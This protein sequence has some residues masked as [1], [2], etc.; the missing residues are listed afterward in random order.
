M[1]NTNATRWSGLVGEWFGFRKSHRRATRKL[2]K[3]VIETLEPRVLLST[4]MNTN[5]SGG[6][7]LRA[8]I[9]AA[10]TAGGAQTINFASTLTGQTINL[11]SGALMLNDPNGTLTIVGPTVGSVTV[12]AGGHSGVFDVA[13]GSNAAIS[14]LTITEGIDSG[15]LNSGSLTVSDCTISGNST[16]YRGGGVCNYYGTLTIANSTITRNSATGT[17][18]G[19]Y[20]FTWSPT[21]T[22]ITNSTIEYN[23]AS[24]GGGIGDFG[25]LTLTGCAIVNNTAT[26]TAGGII[27]YG[28]QLFT[29]TNSTISHNIGPGAG[30]IVNLGGSTMRI[31][32]STIAGNI[33]GGIMDHYRSQQVTLNGTIV[34]NNT[35]NGAHDLS[36][37][38]TGTY[39]LVGDGTGGIVG[40]QGNIQGN[41]HLSAL[42]NYGGPTQTM[43]PLPVTGGNPVLGAGYVN[44]NNPITTDQRGFNLPT[45]TSPDI[46]AFQTRALPSNQTGPLE[47]NTTQDGQ[48]EPG[49]L[50]LR[51]AINLANAIRGN[52]T[53]DFAPSLASQPITLTSGSLTLDDTS[54]TLTIDGLGAS[55]LTV[56]GNEQSEVFRVAY[57]SHAKIEELTITGGNDCGLWNGGTL[58]ISDCTITGNS[59]QY[60]GISNMGALTITNSTISGNSGYWVGGVS[61]Y[62]SL[63]ISDSTISGNSGSWVGG[64]YSVNGSATITNSTISG[65]LAGSYDGG[66]LNWNSTLTVTDST[67]AGNSGGGILDAL[68]GAMTYLSGTIVADNT[69]ADGSELAGQ[70]GSFAGSYN[71]IG[72]GTGGL[73]TS[74]HNVLPTG[75]ETTI[76]PLLGSLFYNGGPTETMA[77]LPG[78]PALCQGPPT[79]LTLVTVDQRGMSRP[80]SGGDIGAFQSNTIQVNTTSDSSNTGSYISLR[81]AINQAD[82]LANSTGDVET[83]TFA[84][85]LTGT[86]D[87]TR[88]ALTIYPAS[89][90]VIVQG[91]GAG[92]L[93]VNAG[94]LSDVFQVQGS[95]SVE[96]N[97]LTI[98]GGSASNGAGVLVP[99]GSGT[100]ITLNDCAITGNTAAGKGGGIFVGSGTVSVIDSTISGNTADL[101]GWG[102]GGGGIYN[103]ATLSLTGC[104][105]SGNVAPGGGGGALFNAHYATVTYCTLSNNSAEY[106]GA[107]VNIYTLTISNSTFSSNVARD[108]G[109]LYNYGGSATI[110]DCTFNNDS[111]SVRGGAIQNKGTLAIS[112]STLSHN[113]A[114][115]GGALDFDSDDPFVIITDCTINDNTAQEGGAIFS[116]REFYGRGGVFSIVDSTVTGN[117]AS[118]TGAAVYNGAYSSA[119]ITSS[120]FNDNSAPVAPTIFNG[121]NATLFLSG[122]VQP[123]MVASLD[124]DGGT[125]E[126]AGTMN[127][128]GGILCLSPGNV[129]GALQ[130]ESGASIVDGT[131]QE[132]SGTDLV[133]ENSQMASLDQ[134]D[135]TGAGTVIDVSQN[136]STL[137]ITDGVA[138]TGTLVIGT[139][140]VLEFANTETISGGTINAGQNGLF[141][142]GD[143][144][145]S[146]VIEINSGA[147]VTLAAGTTLEGGAIIEPTP[148]DGDATMV[149]EG[150]IAATNNREVGLQSGVTFTNQGL[151]S[152]SDL[153]AF[154]DQS[155]TFVGAAMAIS[156]TEVVFGWA[157]LPMN[158][159]DSYQILESTDGTNYS[160]IATTL[161][162][163]NYDVVE[164]LEPN[165]TYYFKVEETSGSV[166]WVYTSEQVITDITRPDDYAIGYEYEEGAPPYGVSKD[167]SG[168]FQVV[169]VSDGSGGTVSSSEYDSATI[170][171]GSPQGALLQ[172]VDRLITTSVQSDTVVLPMAVDVN[173]QLTPV[174]PTDY[175]ICLASDPGIG[176]PWAWSRWIWH[177]WPILPGNGNGGDPINYAT[178]DTEIEDPILSSSAFNGAWG[179]TLNWTQQDVFVPDTTFGNG[180]MNESQSF[181]ENISDGESN[182]AILLVQDAYNQTIFLNSGSNKY[183][184]LA[185]SPGT[186]TY[187]DSN[188]TYTWVNTTT[189]AESIYRGFSD[190]TD[191]LQGKLMQYQDACG[192]Q[193]NLTYSNGF[194]QT[195]TQSDAAGDTETFQYTYNENDQISLIQQ[196]IQR[197]G[198]SNAT[199][200][201]QAVFTYYHGTYLGADAFG[202]LGDLK[203][204]TV[205]DGEGNTVS[206]NYYRYYTP[207][208]LTPGQNFV[209]GLQY[210]FVGDSFT[211][212]LAAFS[213]PFSVGNEQVAPHADESYAYDNARRVIQEVVGSVGESSSLGQGTYYFG[214]SRNLGFSWASA[215]DNTWVTYTTE[216]L[217]DGNQNI[218]YTNTNGDELLD[219][220]NVS[221][222]PG[223]P[224]NVGDNWILGY[225][226]DPGTGWPIRT[227][228]SSAFNWNTGILAGAESAN[229]IE[230]AL[231]PYSDLV[232]FWQG[233]TYSS[234]GLIDDTTYYPS[235]DDGGAPGFIDAEYVQQGWDGN[236][237]EQDSYTY[238]AHT[239]ADGFT[240]YPVATYTQYQSAADGGSSPET[241][242]YDYNTWQN[243]SSGV[244]NQ[245]QEETTINPIVSTSQDGS[246]T[247]TNT[248]TVYNAF[249]Q[250]VWTMD[251]D[252]YITYTAYDNVTGAVIQNVKN[253]NTYSLP[254][255]A[256]YT[257]TT[258]TDG[259]NA[260][261][262]PQLPAGWTTP[263]GGGLMN[264]V[265][266]HYVDDLGRT[267]EQISPAGNITLYVY[268]DPHHATFT[269]PG[270]ILNTSN[271]TLTTTGPITMVRS[272]IP[273]SYAS[274]TLEGVYDETITFSANTPI[275][276]TGGTSGEPIVP[277][278][279][280]FIQGDSATSG[281][282]NVFNLTGNGTTSSPQFTIQS[283]TRDLY[284]NSGRTEGQMVESDAYAE[285]DNAIYLATAPGSPYSGS[286]I[287]NQ[288]SGQAPNGN[289]YPTYHGHDAD[290]R[291]YQVIDA[292]G[293]I[294]DRVFDSMNRLVSYWTGTDDAVSGASGTP[295]YFVG[296]NAG[297]GNNMTEVESYV[298]DNGGVGDCNITEAIQYPDGNTAGTQDVGIYSYDFEDRLIAT[299]GGLTLNS[300]G[301]VTASSSDPYPLITVQTLDNLG[302]VL[303]TLTFNGGATSLSAAI[304]AAASAEAGAMLTGLV[305][306]STSQYDAENNDYEDQT[307]SVDPNSGAIS[308]TALR[309][310]TFYDGDGN[311]I[312]TVAPSGLATK[313][314]YDGVGD[315]VD[316]FDTDGGA[317]NNGGSPV[318]TYTAASNASQDV[319]V[320]QTAYGYDADGSLIETAGAQRLNTDSDSAAGALFTFTVNSND[321]LDV[322]ANSSIDS[323]IDYTASYYDQADRDIADV[324]FGTSTPSFGSLPARSPN[325]QV[326]TY[327]YDAAG[328]QDT[329]T[330]PGNT[331]DP[332][333]VVTRSYFDALGDVTE[334]ISDYTNGT[335]TNNSNQTTLY[336]YDG[337]GDVTSET[338]EM[339]VGTANQT[340]DYAYGVTTAGGSTI[341]SNDLLGEAKYPDPSTGVPGGSTSDD[342]TCTY[343]ALG[344]VTSLKDRNGT[345]HTYAYDTAGRL[346]TDTAVVAANNPENVDTTVTKLTYS[347]NSLGLPFEQTSLNSSD[348][349]V[350]QVQDD[351][352]GLGQLAAQYQSVSGPVSSGSTPE[353]QYA[354]SD[355]STGSRL[356]EMIYPN[357]RILYYGYNNN[358]LDNAIGRVDYLA[359]ANGTHDVDYYYLGLSTIIS[360]AQGNGVKETTSLNSLGEVAQMNYVNTITSA[361]TDDFQYGYDDDGNVL[362]ED[363][364]VDPSLSELFTYDNLD[365]LTSYEQ[366]TL[367]VTDTGIVGTPTASQSWTYDALGNQAS[368]N[369]QNELAADGYDKNGN[370][371]SDQSGN[372]YVY[373][374]WNQLVAVKNSGGTT[375]ASYTYDAN[376]NRISQTE[377]GPTTDF[378]LSCQGQVIEEVQGATVTAQNVWNIDYVNDLLQRTQ[379]TTTYYV[380][381]DANFNVTAITDTSGNVKERFTYGP[382]GN[383][384]VL[385]ANT[386]QPT[387]DQYN[388]VYMFQGGRHDPA[389][390]LYHFGARD[391]STALGTW[392]EQDPAGYVNGAD[393]YE[394]VQDNPTTD[395]DPLGLGLSKDPLNGG[396]RPSPPDEPKGPPPYRIGPIQQAPPDRLNGPNGPVLHFKMR[397]RCYDAGTTQPAANVPIALSSNP[398]TNDV[399]VTPMYDASDPKHL[400]PVNVTDE[401]GYY[402]FNL[403]IGGPGRTIISVGPRGGNNPTTFPV[404]WPPP[405]THPS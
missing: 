206:E 405:S 187:D 199:V 68:S 14:G 231:E 321:S 129:G 151:V 227:F 164:D 186:L 349:V 344:E 150:V 26:S 180:W 31:T 392:V 34:A 124:D 302:D 179:V 118:Q 324:N 146:A 192:N 193:I 356:T 208:E 244:T 48:I 172:A 98:T 17:G 257:G 207:A 300:S 51:D 251:E 360:Q 66:I 122:M 185:K 56:N 312:E 239:N 262:V 382:Y 354:Y 255:L 190:S 16:A 340:T 370:M 374:A 177:T 184:A 127:L 288:L 97:D 182:A 81:E 352:N 24:Y 296:S 95:A 143:E 217:P 221:S 317:V 8:A 32:D 2:S 259:Y 256:N 6:G 99:A 358:A 38:F 103:V 126:L 332:N 96:I 90:E 23:S 309:T 167:M 390:G 391:Y 282:A 339:P 115:Y 342:E 235:S 254:Y 261:G 85:T 225:E 128:D 279:P 61:N 346:I 158:A 398:P 19:I 345:T 58:Q 348:G 1:I 87:L 295:S 139:N 245:V 22:T 287:T 316:T 13:S 130:L 326:T 378:Y 371:V 266:T 18:G 368:V 330:D 170:A 80:A 10:D 341:D 369:D 156:P 175:P 57:Y 70:S 201:R 305:G 318:L 141:R 377:N 83:V 152:V 242:T 200:F 361:S 347:Y 220:Q 171:A 222:D 116:G 291:N 365:R 281:A 162:L 40:S 113:V 381:H 395:V 136:Q 384:T 178:G 229:D 197:V 223:N 311:V 189:G 145:Q 82:Q 37:Y 159:G 292:N 272:D 105:L 62:D 112:T 329:T 376:G 49:Q 325:V 362:Y 109:A 232:F 359:E 194:L 67:I 396:A 20:N 364:T 402:Y 183:T 4:V 327:G 303:G 270:V 161:P 268:D 271:D 53:I 243:N 119:T 314:V 35:S 30:G 263:S 131:I 236:A 36:G 297:A 134:A 125:V 25:S 135:V 168:F 366:G 45:T 71:L 400:R 120:T 157:G 310:Y 33:G 72:D 355:P 106:G 383:V 52:E 205:E 91:P 63:T 249:G 399:V 92:V 388:W 191:P 277:L 169:N 28:N 59:G 69:A 94:D 174:T 102:D 280:G 176:P 350:N 29:I 147:T 163:G 250:P 401:D 39:N 273:Y 226:Y 79:S 265:T 148:T 211:K 108:G 404:N 74:N 78:S 276:Y 41:P 315:L 100:S 75:S 181:L 253:V 373:N 121:Y 47:V 247:A 275:S 363:N 252:G 306:F 219:V 204:V 153:G 12:S 149:N 224:A 5:D 246:G 260:Y 202:N 237:I 195:V 298:Y 264:L 84:S 233:A 215:N 196:S 77:L 133:V 93:A 101:S 140:A 160:T 337:L 27:N 166:E 248:Q 209:G 111:A 188:N 278:L 301:A 372:T 258:F 336:N 11:I 218:V 44:V 7:S 284:N 117:T 214:Y 142:N 379:G 15:I 173:G 286:Q 386:G 283:L 65:N 155:E 238:F 294:H 107:I 230:K 21:T 212:L 86:I 76:D 274:G 240:F 320:E 308:T 123:S 89:G 137:V 285:I 269:L 50:S 234:Q 397:A 138:F 267:I 110:A 319:V 385:D 304:A 114:A 88:G 73:S 9:L 313:N 46:G 333:G 351:Y 203:T 393:L 289:Y 3:A 293:T 42:D 64:I 334:T 241:T 343:D 299:E 165:A 307:Y 394:F 357:E 387:T 210:A 338:A 389:T 43:V 380:Q 55:A 60:G 328:N 331:T 132:N 290:G 322:T 375:I 216:T 154:A 104:T 403:Y 213:D 228:Q 367:N 54:G 144:E 353:V 335:P 198:D 323:M